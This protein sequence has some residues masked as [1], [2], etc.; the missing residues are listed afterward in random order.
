MIQ[1]NVNPYLPIH[2]KHVSKHVYALQGGLKRIPVQDL[3]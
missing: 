3:K 1:W 2:N